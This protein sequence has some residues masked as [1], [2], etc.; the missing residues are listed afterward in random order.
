MDFYNFGSYDVSQVVKQYKGKKLEELFQNHEI[1]KNEMGEFM[2]ILWEIDENN[3]SRGFNLLITKKNLLHNLKTVYNIGEIIEKRLKGRGIKT[4][5]DLKFILKYQNSANE[6]LKLINKKDFSA[7]CTNRYIND[8][9]VSFCFDL[10]EFLF[11][12]IETLGLYNSPVIIIGLG[13]FRGKKFEIH[14][15]LARDLEEEIAIFEHLKTEILPNFSCFVSYN[16]KCF[17]VPYIA[18]RFF[19]FFNETP[20]VSNGK[21]NNK[22][23]HI[24]L[25]HNCRRKFK[26]KFIS[27]SLTNMEEQLLNWK[28][29]NEL[30]SNMVGTCYKKYKKNP[31]KYVGLIK[32]CIEHNYYDIYSMPL[33]FQKLLK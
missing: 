28:R 11:L 16:G 31:G 27:Y 21:S 12:D 4:L 29:N 22:Y 18:N 1:I 20:I 26:G 8:L 9:D 33:I 6:V 19:Y 7:L 13:Y 10:K 15:L 17:D 2:E 23:H 14:V 5:N 24:D 3:L 25:L 30:P 32:E